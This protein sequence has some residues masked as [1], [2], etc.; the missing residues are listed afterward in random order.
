[1]TTEELTFFDTIAPKWDSMEVKSTPAKIQELLDIIEITPGCDVLD[2][3][4]GTG[5][6]LPYLSQIAGEEGTVTAVDFSEGMLA[7]AE[8]KFSHLSNVYFS[9]LDFEE[10]REPWRY[11]LIMMYCVYPHLS[12]P[13]ETLRRLVAENLKPGGRIIIGFP[14]DEKFINSI[15]RDHAVEDDLGSEH[16]VSAPALAS[17]ISKWGLRARVLAYNP[18]KY[19]VE[20]KE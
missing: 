16:L 7:E 18:G 2:L 4:T 17:R 9:R 11:D 8:K 13:R 20:V 3:G 19:L 10:E 6:L 1:M 15:H 12:Y 5:V 14:T